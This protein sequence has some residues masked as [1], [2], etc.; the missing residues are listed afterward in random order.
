[1]MYGEA[2]QKMSQFIHGLDPTGDVA[3]GMAGMFD[4]GIWFPEA[5][6]THMFWNSDGTFAQTIREVSA[7]PSV[8][9]Q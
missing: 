6:T 4:D 2:A 9:M 5:V 1:M 7:R 3:L 8:R